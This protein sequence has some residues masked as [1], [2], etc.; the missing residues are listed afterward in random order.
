MI[1]TFIVSG[2]PQGKARPRFVVKN[3][4]ARVYTPKATADYEAAIAWA[5]RQKYG[6]SFGG[7]PVGMIITATMPIPQSA[8]HA[9]KSRMQTGWLRPTVKPDWDNIGKIVA[10][11]LNGVA[12]DDDKQIVEA[13][14][15]KFYGVEPK[16][17]VVLYDLVPEVKA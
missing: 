7:A 9:E 1:R 17:T 3:G 13:S 15:Q 12:Y 5:Y 8:P 11:A 4:L 6:D 2:K 16:L 10:D 14:I